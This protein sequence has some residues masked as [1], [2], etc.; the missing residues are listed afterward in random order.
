MSSDEYHPPTPPPPPPPEKKVETPRKGGSD[1]VLRMRRTKSVTRAEEIQ[2]EEKK[3]RE[4]QP[5]H[6]CHKPRD[7]LFSWSSGFENF[8]GFVNWAFLL[9]LIG[10]VRLMLEN[11]LKYGV[12][13]DPRQWWI[14]LMQSADNPS[15]TGLP[16]L[17]LIL[18]SN[19]QILFTL[20]NEKL[21]ASYF[22]SE[23][24]GLILNIS[25]LFTFLLVPIV[26]INFV[27][28]GDFSMMGGTW[29]CF[30]YCTTFF[31]LT[32]FCHVN[33]WCRLDRSCKSSRKRRRSLSHHKDLGSPR[34]STDFFGGIKSEATPTPKETTDNPFVEKQ[35]HYPD[36]LKV[37]SLYYFI[38]APTLCYELN[39]PRTSRIRKR[40]LVRRII[41]VV[42]G[43][44][45]L[46]CL[47]QQWIVPSVKNSLIPFSKMDE[48]KTGERLLKLA[49]PNHL[50]WLVWFY[51]FFHSWLNML[52]ELLQ[53]A[54]RDY[55]GDWWNADNLT[56]FW[57]TWNLP[58]HRWAIRHLYGPLCKRGFKR[59]SSSVAVFFV[60]AFFHEYL[61]SVPLRLF[62]VWAFTGM[63]FQIPL[64]WCTDFVR[65]NFGARWAN[66]MV[67]SSLILGQPLCIMMYF[68]DFVIE[69]YGPSLLEEFTIL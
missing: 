57:R 9:L 42:L 10:G 64:S 50:L 35:V 3:L 17:C 45:L 55:Y 7:S 37:S 52:G 36:N 32:S 2:Y 67:W 5:D 58:A 22:L 48:L 27:I 14:I 63:M 8:S 68:H 24:V 49:I 20:V 51:L 44:N 4:Q 38:F 34:S 25:S 69:H 59:F 19:C 56:Y 65:D 6:P 21:M 40:F 28:P 53:F 66:V 43:G 16:S 13:V 26:A 60:S 39:F 23:R 1:S 62:K 30:V 29:V 54:D 46:F 31:K 15:S 33:Y 18:A 61:V 47:I 12:R 41:E 11:L